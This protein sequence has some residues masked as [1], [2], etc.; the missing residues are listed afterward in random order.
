MMK[1]TISGHHVEITDAIKQAIENKFNKVAKHF[2]DLMT[3]ESIITVEPNQQ[4]LEVT[5]FY[6]GSKV[7]VRASGKELYRAIAHAADKLHSALK[8]RKG[9]LSKKLHQKYQVEQSD[10]FQPA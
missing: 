8:H 1:I 5:T 10:G 3:I 4:K 6:E 7:S 2:P 9:M